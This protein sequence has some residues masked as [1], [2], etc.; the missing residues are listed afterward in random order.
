MEIPQYVEKTLGI[1]L[2]DD[3]DLSVCPRALTILG[4]SFS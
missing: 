2:A 3:A 4:D 1:Y